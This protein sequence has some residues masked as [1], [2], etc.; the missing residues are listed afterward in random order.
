MQTDS[1]PRPSVVDRKAGEAGDEEIPPAREGAGIPVPREAI[2]ALALL[3][4]IVVILFFQATL[5]PPQERGEPTP[6][7]L[8]DGDSP[9]VSPGIPPE[10]P[11]FNPDF[12]TATPGPTRYPTAYPTYSPNA[13]PAPAPNASRGFLINTTTGPYT[14]S[15]GKAMLSV[16]K[17][18]FVTGDKYTE[19][20]DVRN[21]GNET[22]DFSLIDAIPRGMGITVYDASF[23]GSFEPL[24]QTM[25]RFQYSLLP[26]EKIKHGPTILP[27]GN[28]TQA[29]ANFFVAASA[30][31]NET[32]YLDPEWIEDHPLAPLAVQIALETLAQLNS[33]DLSDYDVQAVAEEAADYMQATNGIS[34]QLGIEQPAWQ[35]G[36]PSWPGVQ[37]PV[38]CK[39]AKPINYSKLSAIQLQISEN[40]PMAKFSIPLD[41]F[42]YNPLDDVSFSGK[43]TDY[44]FSVKS[45]V[46]KCSMEV[47]LNFSPTTLEC[48]LYPFDKISGTVTLGFP[49]HP[50]KIFRVPVQIT[51]IHQDLSGGEGIPQ[52]NCASA[53]AVLQKASSHL[54]Q[55]PE[56]FG[57]PNPGCACYAGTVFREAGISFSGSAWAPQV[58]QDAQAK[59]GKVISSFSDL[60]PGDLVFYTGTY[61]DFPPGT[62]TH[63]EIYVGGGR[64]IGSGAAPVSIKA[65]GI[66]SHFYKGVR[67]IKC[68]DAGAANASA[69]P[70][71]SPEPGQDAITANCSG[72]T[73]G[74]MLLSYWKNEAG[75]GNGLSPRCYDASMNA[76]L[77]KYLDQNGLRKRGFDKEL[78]LAL[79]M[80]ESG[81]DPDPGNGQGIMQVVACEG[82]CGLEQ[83]IDAGTKHLADDYDTVKSIGAKGGA[84]ATLT[85]FSYNRGV[86]T[87][88]MAARKTVGGMEVK[89]AMQEA[90]DSYFS[91]DLCTGPGLGPRYP[92]RVAQYY[93]GAIKHKTAS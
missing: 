61:G 85:F 73:L 66:K 65:D 34:T 19:S 84:L 63:V 69:S 91:A 54:G 72:G 90:C 38:S 12:P 21:I 55:M 45:S 35:G 7:A 22:A 30:T 74:K 42:G 25:A 80:T 70:Q 16:F 11:T 68:D 46:R 83:N 43:I 62:I 37:N 92:E 2:A 13:S 76:I 44:P 56:A 17:R 47:S 52:T 59:G 53:N 64:T 33:S 36:L 71:P 93:A 81:C 4:A 79:M 10:W 39:R 26:G 60:K 1:R 87:A 49:S 57:C 88:S 40:A 5:V 3:A 23:T 28:T 67:L 14:Y 9:S 51:V 82:S 15:V 27:I 50:S 29:I 86:G 48:G 77:T 89:Q 6:P 75:E 58:F 20:L 18:L 24:S 32:P 8:P 78:V 31:V 41:E